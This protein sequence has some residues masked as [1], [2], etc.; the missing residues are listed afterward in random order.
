MEYNGMLPPWERPEHTEGYEGFY[1]L[2][3]MQGNEEHA[4]LHYIIRDHDAARFEQ[5][6]ETVLQIGEYLNSRYGADTVQVELKDSYN[7]KG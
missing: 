1:H 6:K 7:F 5:R 2:T 4:E 3:G